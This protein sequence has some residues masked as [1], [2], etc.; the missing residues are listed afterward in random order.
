MSDSNGMSPT[1]ESE[2]YFARIGLFMSFESVQSNS[3][4]V[5]GCV[6]VATKSRRFS[7][8]VFISLVLSSLSSLLAFSLAPPRS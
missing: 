3:S 1:R 4:C 8:S 6:K 7:S 2:L 5:R